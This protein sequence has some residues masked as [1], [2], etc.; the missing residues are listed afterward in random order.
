MKSNDVAFVTL[1]LFI[2]AMIYFRS[3]SKCACTIG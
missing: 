2:G 3:T 1:V